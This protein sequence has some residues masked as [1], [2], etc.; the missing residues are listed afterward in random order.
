MDRHDR[1]TSPRKDAKVAPT[2]SEEEHRHLDHLLPVGNDLTFPQRATKPPSQQKY[3]YINVVDQ[4]RVTSDNWGMRG[5]VVTRTTGTNDEP[6]SF[7]QHRNE[8]LDVVSPSSSN[9]LNE[10]PQLYPPKQHIDIEQH[11]IHEVA[12]LYGQPFTI[13]TAFSLQIPD[14]EIQY[15]LMGYDIFHETRTSK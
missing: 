1:F 11:V 2:Q 13:E 4:P 6:S 8:Q 7:Q 12:N 10:E 9:K 15:H 3:E 14:Q 5:K